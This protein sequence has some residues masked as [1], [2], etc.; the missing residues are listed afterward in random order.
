MLTESKI[1]IATTPE[2]AYGLTSQLERW[3]EFLPHYRSI[4]ILDRE[5]S[6]MTV[7]MSA[8]RDFLPVSWTSKFHADPDRLELHFYHLT[9]F[10]KGMEVVWTYSPVP[11]GVLITIKHDLHFRIPFLATAI[12]PII[13]N[14]FIHHI[15]TKTLTTFKKI[16]EAHV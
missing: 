3:P 8:W 2:A 7:K 6:S 12:E 9:A 10:T 14:Y 15:A 11:D 5:P 13:E 16:L 1:Q 4:H